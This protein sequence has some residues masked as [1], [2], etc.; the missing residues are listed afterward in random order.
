MGAD[1]QRPDTN[2]SFFKVLQKSENYDRFKKGHD[3]EAYLRLGIYAKKSLADVKKDAICNCGHEAN[4]HDEGDD[5][6]M[7]VQHL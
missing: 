1:S 7:F 3:G 5:D 6:V 4:D 2:M